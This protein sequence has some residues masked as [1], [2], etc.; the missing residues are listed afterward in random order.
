MGPTA[1][2]LPASFAGALVNDSDGP[3]VQLLAVQ[4]LHYVLDIVVTRKFNDTLVSFSSMGISIGNIACTSHYI[5]KI[6]P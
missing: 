5:L 2:A 4:L 1:A 6:L 3:A